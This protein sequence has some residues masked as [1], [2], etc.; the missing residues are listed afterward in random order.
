MLFKRS[1]SLIEGW[2]L[3]ISI[4]SKNDFWFWRVKQAIN[5]ITE[6]SFYL[7]NIATHVSHSLLFSIYTLFSLKFDKFFIK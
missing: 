7:H 2:V 6:Y 4:A 3:D 1:K 5:G